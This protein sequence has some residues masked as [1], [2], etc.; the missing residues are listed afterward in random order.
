MHFLQELDRVFSVLTIIWTVLSVSIGFLAARWLYVTKHRKIR[1]ILSLKKCD[2]KIVLSKYDNREV[3]KG[4]SLSVCPI[5]DIQA[6]INVTD[7]IYATGLY[8]NQQSIIHEGSYSDDITNYNI[9]CIGGFLANTFS[10]SLFNLI[11]PKFKI[12][13]SSKEINNVTEDTNKSSLRYFK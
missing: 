8:S 4:V 9:F 3:R 10:D 6:A 7:L 12:Y 5:G 2:C 13:A 11:F 1:K